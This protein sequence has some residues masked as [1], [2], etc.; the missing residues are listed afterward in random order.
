MIYHLVAHQQL[1]CHPQRY[2]PWRD[3]LLRQGIRVAGTYDLSQP[4]WQAELLKRMAPGDRVLALGGDGTLN[5]VAQLCVA[6]NWPLALLPAGTANDCARALSIPSDPD[7]ACKLLRGRAF[8]S[9]E[10]RAVDVGRLNGRVFLNVAHIGLGAEVTWSLG[11]V[12]K[13]LWGGYS[14]LRRLLKLISGRRRFSARIEADGRVM[15]GPWL[16]IAIANGPRFG[17]GHLIEGAGFETGSLTLVAIRARPLPKVLLAWWAARLGHSLDP[18]LVRVEH[19]QNCRIITRR[20]LK[21]TADGERFGRT[22]VEF[23]IEPQV[24][25]VLVPLGGRQATT[26]VNSDQQQEGGS[27][28]DQQHNVMLYATSAHGMELVDRYRDLAEWHALAPAIAKELQQLAGEREQLLDAFRLEV[29]SEGGVP[30]AGN[31]DRE[32]LDSL[33]D[34]WLSRLSG[35]GATL[36]RLQQAEQVWLDD[37]RILSHETWSAPLAEL[38]I[39]LSQ[40]GRHSQA[41]LSWMA[42]H[43]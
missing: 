37:I 41:R 6:H 13:R 23:S 27:V 2:P 7:Q 17:G 11:H 1:L 34:R 8:H 20:R 40:H 39:S 32:F 22:P 4:G 10:L 43:C 31:P 25:R 12:H 26:R 15:Q 9:G 19:V 42:D 30:K 21:V 28:L 24:L 33:A 18:K 5:A 36:A 35:I 14:Y 38:L 16:E 3:A 29:L